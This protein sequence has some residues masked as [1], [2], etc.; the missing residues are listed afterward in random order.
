MTANA[1]GLLT[2]C[3]MGSTTEHEY[4]LLGC[5]TATVAVGFVRTGVRFVEADR[6]NSNL[7]LRSTKTFKTIF[8]SVVRA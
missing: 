1:A 3:F 7:K 6:M 4:D 5:W 8:S 2:G